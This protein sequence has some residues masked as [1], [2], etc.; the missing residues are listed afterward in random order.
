MSALQH[1]PPSPAREGGG[2][3][4]EKSAGPPQLL[5]GLY[6]LTFT[7]YGS[8]LP[9]FGRRKLKQDKYLLASPESRALVR[10]AI[11]KVCKFRGWVLY[12]LHVR[13]NHVHGIVDAEVSPSRIF[14]DWKA[15]ATRSLGDP[16][17]IHW[18]RGGSARRIQTPSGLTRAMHYVLHKQG[19]LMQVYWSDPRIDPP[20]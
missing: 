17:R 14:N 13:T 8:H 1:T 16:G 9:A 20:P 11:V 12:A 10:D 3:T 2:K 15:Y 6:L 19:E 18:S 4:S 7:C 5:S